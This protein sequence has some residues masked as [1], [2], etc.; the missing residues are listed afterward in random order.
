MS[1][2]SAAELRRLRGNGVAM[3]YQ[4]PGKALN[5]SLTV[6]RQLAEIFELGGASRAQAV[7]CGAASLRRVRIADPVA[8]MGRYPHQLSGGM[9]QRVCIA[10]ALAG[11]PALLVLDEPTTGLDATVEAEVLDLVAQLRREFTTSILFISHN[12]A[13]VAGMCDRVGVLYA[14]TLVEEGSAEQVFRDPRHPY[15]VVL[16]RCLPRRGQRK[17]QGRLDTIA[18]FLPTPG[19]AIRGCAFAPRCA[20]A[21]ERCRT[22]D[23][24]FQ[25]SRRATQP[26]S[27]S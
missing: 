20:L 9:Q 7:E 2:R 24:P 13:V 4:D 19:A 5:P 18:G 17:D 14:G 10:A 12:L 16:L 22:Q 23:P 26:L 3:V 15:T 27:L 1:W 11:N 21:D 25:R 8:V 6:G